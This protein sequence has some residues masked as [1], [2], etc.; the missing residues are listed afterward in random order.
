MKLPTIR[1]DKPI[2]SARWL[3]NNEEIEIVNKNAFLLKPFNYGQS[4]SVRVAK[5]QLN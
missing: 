3:D 2:K 4:Y 1:I 5:I